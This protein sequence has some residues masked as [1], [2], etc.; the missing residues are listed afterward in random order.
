[1]TLGSLG[2]QSFTVQVRRPGSAAV[3]VHWSPY[4]KASGG[5]VERDGEWTR[6]IA[7][8]AGSLHVGMS[9]SPARIFSR[10]RRCG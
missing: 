1:M 7:R 8:R 9:F 2:L 3:K 5:C 4:W 6:V 10:G